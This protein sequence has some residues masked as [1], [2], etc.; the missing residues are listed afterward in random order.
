MNIEERVKNTP[1]NERPLIDY[2]GNIAHMNDEQYANYL[3]AQ[4]EFP[5]P[6]DPHPS[7]EQR[8]IELE[9]QLAALTDGYKEGVQNA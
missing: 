1:L 7:A 5:K 4:E 9:S 3:K 6:S 8:I 2:N